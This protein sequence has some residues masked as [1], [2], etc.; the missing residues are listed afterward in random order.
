M[1]RSCVTFAT[2]PGG[3]ALKTTIE[4]LDIARA[5]NGGC[6]DYRLAQLLEI[7]PSGISNYRS[8]R[9]HP[10]NPIAKRLGELCKLDPAEVVCWVNLERATSPE[11]RETWNLLLSRV[12]PLSNRRKAH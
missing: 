5:Q 8:G 11:D 2:E 4:L 3:S 10:A 7:P 9:S 1:F 6:S 12:R